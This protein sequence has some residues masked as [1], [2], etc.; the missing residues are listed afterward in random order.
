M[1][2]QTTTI[3]EQDF[4]GWIQHNITLLQQGRWADID[5]NILIE[6]LDGMAKRD[7]HEL[8]SH[9][10]I[11]I[12]HLLKWQF[13]LKQLS[14]YRESWQGGSWQATI[15]EQRLQIIRQ[16]ELS[17]SLKPHLPEAIS[18]AYPAAAILAVKETLLPK[19]TFPDTCP[20]SL[21]Q[22]LD[23][24]FYPEQSV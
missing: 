16:L 24:E 13:Q 2:D 1:I 15:I 17:P 18:K 10:I 5:I 11:L 20:Y 12:A 22:L 6:E 14:N 21:E 4:Y 19:S 7:K 9:L 8:V 23:D 3:Y